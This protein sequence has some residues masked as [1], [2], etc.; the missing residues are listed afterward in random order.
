MNGRQCK[1]LR[2]MSE[3]L[4]AVDGTTVETSYQFAWKPRKNE[5]HWRIP[6]VL[7]PSARQKY[8]SMKA[9]YKRGS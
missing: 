5:P 2:R 6:L 7:R 1:A 8:Q 4:C 9:V 3:R